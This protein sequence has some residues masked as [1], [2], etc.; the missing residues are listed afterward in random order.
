MKKSTTRLLAVAVI[1]ASVAACSNHPQVQ[2][3]PGPSSTNV[4]PV[5]GVRGGS[6]G[7][8]PGTVRTPR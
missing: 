4:N 7:G 1:V 3:P 2:P 8:D 6:T 5:T